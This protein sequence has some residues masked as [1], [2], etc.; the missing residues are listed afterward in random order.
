MSRTAMVKEEILR[1]LQAGPV[2][3]NNASGLLAELIGV[4]ADGVFKDAMKA[5]VKEGLVETVVRGRRTQRLALTNGKVG[6][7]VVPPPA[8]APKSSAKKASAKKAAAPKKAAV[9]KSA[10]TATLKGENDDYLIVPMPLP[11]ADEVAALTYSTLTLADHLATRADEIENRLAQ[12]VVEISMLEQE[13]DD[14][15]D[16]RAM[17]NELAD[18]IE[19]RESR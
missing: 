7:K 2:A 1:E 16:E 13:S 14:L 8:V 12:I 5:L 18:H 15:S 11:T 4:P 3:D 6:S 17:V 10:P 19:T 9:K